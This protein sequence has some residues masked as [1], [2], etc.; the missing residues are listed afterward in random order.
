MTA[1]LPKIDGMLIKGRRSRD[2]C[3]SRDGSWLPER[4][5]NYEYSIN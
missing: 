2:G 3:P 4:Q 5:V 1:A